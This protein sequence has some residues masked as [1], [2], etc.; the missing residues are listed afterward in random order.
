M[1]DTKLPKSNASTA[2]ATTSSMGDCSLADV[3]KGYC[4]EQS[5]PPPFEESP[6]SPF[7]LRPGGFLTRP[8]GW[9]R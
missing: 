4:V 8:G 6:F 5:A 7:A 2:G 1:D 9:E 3:R